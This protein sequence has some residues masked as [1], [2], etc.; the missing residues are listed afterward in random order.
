M[1]FKTGRAQIRYNFYAKC[2]STSMNFNLNSFYIDKFHEHT[3]QIR[4]SHY[5]RKATYDNRATAEQTQ[6][7]TFTLTTIAERRQSIKL[8]VA[9]IFNSRK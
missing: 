5:R 1:T 8:A 2:I 3:T 9:T 7:T 4:S 6:N